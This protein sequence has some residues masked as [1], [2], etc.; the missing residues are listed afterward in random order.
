M[1]VLVTGSR[2]LI[3]AALV[4]RLT[5][6]GHEVHTTGRQTS[7][8]TLHH[9]ADLAVGAQAR[10]VLAAAEPEAVVH[11]AGGPAA[12]RH[13]LYRANVLTTVSLLEAAVDSASPP[14]VV[15][16]GSA[17]EYGEGDGAPIA[18]TAPL[19]PVTEYGRAK[20]A[21]T[22]LAEVLGADLSLA[23]ARPFNV[24]SGGMPLSTALGN[25]RRQL[26]DQSGPR[27]VVRCGRIDIVRDFVPLDFVVSALATLAV[28]GHRGTFNVCSGVGISLEAILAAMAGQLGI[29]LVTEHQPELLALP[30][31]DHVVGN[32]ERLAQLGLVVAPTPADLARLS[33]AP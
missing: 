3:G 9:V 19:R 8:L 5:A 26:L 20:V 28:G 10:K 24:V 27:R 30:A 33:L 18:E 4:S 7:D 1:R 2:G 23:V 11:L 16:V 6:E 14:H 29:E 13:E 15:V 21:A 31:A 25:L 22:T 32:A 17:A 12:D